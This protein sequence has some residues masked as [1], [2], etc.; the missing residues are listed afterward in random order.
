MR[1]ARS[2]RSRRGTSD[3]LAESVEQRERVVAQVVE[4]AADDQRA[5]EPALDARRRGPGTAERG[6]GRGSSGVCP[7]DLAVR[8]GRGASPPRYFHRRGCAR[9]NSS[10]PNGRR[11]RSTSASNGC[12]SYSGFSSTSTSMP[13][14]P[15][16]RVSRA[17]SRIINSLPW[18]S[19]LMKSTRSIPPSASWLSRVSAVDGARLD[20]VE[21]TQRGENRLRNGR[22]GIKSGGIALLGGQVQL[23]AAPAARRGLVRKD[24]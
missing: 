12:C 9:S 24:G 14:T 15:R 21:S 4:Q 11:K 23:E 13:K 18:V 8:R 22:F 2:S 19:S 10:Y 1:T 6:P 7:D 5:T 16:R 20:H 17:P 3:A